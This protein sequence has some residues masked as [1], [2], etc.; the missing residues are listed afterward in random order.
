MNWKASIANIIHQ[1]IKWSEQ[2]TTYVESK[3]R[4]SILK[5]H[6]SLYRLYACIKTESLRLQRRREKRIKSAIFSVCLVKQTH[7]TRLFLQHSVIAASSQQTS[8]STQR[9]SPIKQKQTGHL[10]FVNLT[11]KQHDRAKSPTSSAVS[12]GLFTC[13][14]V[15]ARMC[16][17]QNLYAW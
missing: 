6:I 15:W 5:T 12:W 7:K 16:V 1:Q 10:D 4:E 14:H 8:P 9:C 17:K 11:C 3:F 13:M 2:N